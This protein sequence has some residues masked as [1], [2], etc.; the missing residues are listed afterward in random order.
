MS[1]KLFGKM[2]ECRHCGKIQQFEWME[3]T[4]RAMLK[5]HACFDCNFWL[6]KVQLAERGF[7]TAPG[8]IVRVK[9]VH[10]IS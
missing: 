1:E 2:I 4:N 7:A 9:G 6:E 10:Y 5:N 8:D 3:S